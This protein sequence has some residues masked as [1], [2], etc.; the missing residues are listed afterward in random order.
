MSDAVLSAQV[1]CE[2]LVPRQH[3]QTVEQ[4][5]RQCNGLEEPSPYQV[6]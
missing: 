3:N 6:K 5:N 4:G 1:A 2:G